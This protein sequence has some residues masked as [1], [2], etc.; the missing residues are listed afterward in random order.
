MGWQDKVAYFVH[1]QYSNPPAALFSILLPGA[2]HHTSLFLGATALGLAVWALRTQW[3]R[4]EIQFF[5]ALGLVALLYGMGR[6]G[7]IEPVLYSL[8]PMV[9]KARSPS[10]AG[11]LFSLSFA[12]L[13]AIG[14][15]AVRQQSV[16][17]GM[18]GWQ[19]GFAAAMTGL[20]LFA[21]LFPAAQSQ[22]EQRW[23]GVAVASG[24]AGLGYQAL[25]TGRWASRQWMG[26]MLAVIL[27]ESA[28]MTYYDM[29]NRH[30][31]N[32]KDLL[33]PMSKHMDVREYLLSRPAPVRITVDD[34][35]IPYN[36]GDWHGVEVMGGYLASL[37]KVHA[38]VDWYTQRTLPL[39][40]VGYHLGPTSR[41][42]G[43][44][45]VFEGEDGIKVWE[46]PVAPMPRAFFVK[47]VLPYRDVNEL[48]VFLN[49]ETLDLRSTALVSEPVGKVEACGEGEAL[50]TRHDS[51]EVKILARTRCQALLVL[52]DSWDAGWEV[53]IDGKPA[54]ALRAYHALRAVV[55]PAGTHAVEWRYSPRGLW[56]GLGCAVL[57]L[58]LFGACWWKQGW[59]S[60]RRILGGEA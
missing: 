11:A 59:A 52:A 43:S 9:E 44:R 21:K 60:G 6:Q 39:V 36:F 18:L 49:T 34:K 19:W 20:F 31:P 28:N 38:D 4:R 3:Q 25:R 27:I 23:F 13:A 10:M 40:G 22:L 15:E 7:L 17:R 56:P 24:I 51:A 42:E 26:L 14:A 2:E 29:G 53:W 12:L 1:E 8:L 35:A 37:T 5:F 47:Q 33:K 32:V 45:I 55:V 48:G 41:M 50:L 54:K 16:G 57:G 58:M 46:Y 30:D